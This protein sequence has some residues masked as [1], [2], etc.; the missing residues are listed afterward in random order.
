[1]GNDSYALTNMS[2]LD[3][4][5][6]VAGER[7]TEDWMVYYDKSKAAYRRATMTT[8]TGTELNY[9][10]ITT[11]GTGAASKAVVLDAS[12]DYTFPASATIVMPS[13]GDL[14]LQSGSTLDVAGTF[15]IA[16]VA[17]TA[18]AAELNYND[19]T[20]LG[21][22]AAS[23]AVVLDASGDYTYPATATIIYP[24]SA[25]LTL[26]SGS[27]FNTAGTFQIGGVA[28]G[29]TAAEINNACDV[30]TRL[31]SIA[32]GTNT[33]SLTAATHANRIVSTLD[34]TLAITLPEATGTGDVYTVLQAI[35]ATSSTIV[36]ADTAN[37]G[38]HGFI[39][40]SDTDAAGTYSWIATGTQDTITFN[41][42]STG[43]K[44]W[45]WIRMT[46]VATDTWLLEGN[47]KQ[48]GGSEATPLSSAA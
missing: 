19:I 47:I 22:G 9:L 24:S 21:T 4:P 30:S 39:M 44:L 5:V 41:G 37:A 28:V 1:M 45:D 34:A 14:T 18:S 16:N 3:I 7:A 8:A 25:T 32:N 42:T 20:T 10:D 31:V 33:L 17:M 48:S 46:D 6:E 27:T 15:E 2:L 35:A 12:G 23:K 26:Q 36:T 29:A 11:L 43:G 40:G 38:F 13:G